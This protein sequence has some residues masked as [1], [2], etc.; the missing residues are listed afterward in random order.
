MQ[1]EGVEPDVVAGLSVGAFAAAVAVG[2]LSFKDGLS[3]SEVARRI[4][5]ESV[6]QGI[7]VSGG[8]RIK[9]NTPFS[10]SQ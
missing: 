8:Y 2:V 3:L 10:N 9:R 7:W 1:A 5:G 4:D 6:S